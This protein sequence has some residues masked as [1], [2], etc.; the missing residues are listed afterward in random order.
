MMSKF[1]VSFNIEC[2]HLTLAL[3]ADVSFAYVK[4]V[5]PYFSNLA[6]TVAPFILS[7]SFVVP[8]IFPFRIPKF[9]INLF[10]VL[11]KKP[12]L[13]LSTTIIQKTHNNVKS[14][15]QLSSLFL[16]GRGGVEPPQS[17]DGRFTVC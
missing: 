15:L 12:F 16:V 9:I 10:G 7:L 13:T 2:L 4:A 14:F 8:T 6:R 1:R 5:I 11:S 17:L 3:F